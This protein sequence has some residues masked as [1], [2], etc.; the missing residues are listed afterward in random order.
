MV[1]DMS[2]LYSIIL[3]GVQNTENG[4]KKWNRYKM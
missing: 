1:G 2:I 3:S 4:L